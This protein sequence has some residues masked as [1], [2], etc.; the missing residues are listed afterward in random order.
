MSRLRIA[1]TGRLATCGLIAMAVTLHQSPARGDG[2]ATGPRGATP[3]SASSQAPLLLA[4][5]E[6]LEREGR[7]EWF[8]DQVTARYSEATLAR[9]VGAGDRRA[10]RAAVVAL[11]LVGSFEVNATLAQALRDDDEG[12]RALAGQA[13]WAVWF[14]AD[15]P[16][17]NAALAEI[18]RLIARGDLDEADRQATRL[19]TRSPRF[20]E[21]YNQRAIAAFARRRY[22]ES[23]ADCLKALEHNPYHFGALGGLGQCYLALGRRVEA[24]ATFRRAAELQPHSRALRDQVAALEGRGD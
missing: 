11:G 9:L 20:A 8:V 10:R 17:N 18:V 14:R 15:T 6:E 13:L 2:S 1:P 19:V 16:E 5:Y 12:V 4:Y 23:A 24:L 7:A 3:M 21:A 22:A